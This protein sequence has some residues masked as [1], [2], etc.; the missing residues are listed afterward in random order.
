MKKP[1]EKKEVRPTSEELMEIMRRSAKDVEELD[2]R[3][4]N[5]FTLTPAQ[6]HMRLD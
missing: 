3:L 4:K 5:V 1:K 6:L 2:R